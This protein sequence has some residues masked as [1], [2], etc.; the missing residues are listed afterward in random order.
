MRDPHVQALIYSVSAEAGTEY[1][2]PE[3]LD[4]QHPLGH[5]RIDGDKL[6][7]E[8]IGHFGT[9]DDAFGQP[10]DDPMAARVE[11][12]VRPLLLTLLVIAT[13]VS[14][15]AAPVMHGDPS[16]MDTA[17]PH[18][19]YVVRQPWHTGIVVL[20]ADV[21]ANAWLA[22]RDFPD[23]AYLEVGWGDRAY[24][25]A[26]DPGV[27][28]GLRALFWPTPGVLHV[29]AFNGPVERTFGSTEILELRVSAR[30][31]ARLVE[32]VRDSQELDASGRP[33]ALGPGLY[34]ASRFYA[35]R[36]K[37]HLFK[38]CNVWTASV[39]LE[40]GIAVSPGLAFSA[41]NLMTQLRPS[42]R[43]IRPAH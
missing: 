28:L 39:L 15:C 11:R 41:S 10:K 43:V 12:S 40:A 8:P 33:I 19:I 29:A 17:H 35:S 13:I 25:Q 26:A 18:S 27:W 14:G 7:I 38:T 31:L 21:P 36:E 37:F 6:R 9:V 23:A 30:G 42:G 20:A 34:G 16:S 1:T 32:V 22:R 2:N 3:P 4:V 5:F 24:Y